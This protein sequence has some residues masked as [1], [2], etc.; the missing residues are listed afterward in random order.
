MTRT[1]HWERETD[2]ETQ[3][4]VKSIHRK[5]KIPS[6][7]LSHDSCLVLSISLIV[8]ENILCF[9]CSWIQWLRIDIG[10]SSMGCTWIRSDV[11]PLQ[12]DGDLGLRSVKHRVC[13]FPLEFCTG[14]DRHRLI[15]CV[16]LT[17]Q[18]FSKESILLKPCFYSILDQFWKQDHK[19]CQV[20][21]I[22]VALWPIIVNS[23]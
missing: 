16:R 12:S 17:I 9:H 8:K 2:C 15:L 11:S 14:R 23:W 7:F 1:F 4:D 6:V 3:P 22:C 10:H 19:G 20:T 21:Y 5:Y 18:N 13:F